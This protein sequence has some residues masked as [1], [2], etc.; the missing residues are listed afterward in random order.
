M[1]LDRYDF[2]NRFFWFPFTELIII[3][4]GMRDFVPIALPYISG[5]ALFKISP[6]VASFNATPRLL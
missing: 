3:K 6:S 2:R 1:S 5:K 4:Y